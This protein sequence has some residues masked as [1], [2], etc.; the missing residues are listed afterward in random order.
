M[1]SNIVTVLMKEKK[2]SLQEAVDYAGVH[3]NHLLDTYL[4]ARKQLSQSLGPEASQFIYSIGQWM[5]GNVV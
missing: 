3:C 4:N 5:I 2:F 1:G